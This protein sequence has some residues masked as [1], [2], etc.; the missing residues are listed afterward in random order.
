MAFNR[1][2]IVTGFAVPPGSSPVLGSPEYG[3]WEREPGHGRYA[4]RLVSNNYAPSGTFSG[5]TEVAGH[6]IVAHGGSSLTY[7]ATI[8]FLDVQGGCNSQFAEQRAG[9]ASSSRLREAP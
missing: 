9:I 2:G 8:R 6:A 1:D 5:T 4:F 3:V 7:S